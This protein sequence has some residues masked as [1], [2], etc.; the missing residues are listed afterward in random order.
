M[1]Y[2]KDKPSPTVEYYGI[3]N[4]PETIIVGRDGKVIMLHAR[5]SKL[6]GEL[7]KLFGPAEKQ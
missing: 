3:T 5:G 1:V 2:G 6:K 7:I 4:I